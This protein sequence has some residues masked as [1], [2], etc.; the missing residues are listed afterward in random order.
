MTNK[1]RLKSDI[2]VITNTYIS[3]LHYIISKISESEEKFFTKE[4]EELLDLTDKFQTR[5]KNEHNK[6]K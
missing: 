1:M 6:S 5:V 2:M 4:F 3:Q